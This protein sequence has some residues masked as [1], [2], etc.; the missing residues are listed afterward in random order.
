MKTSRSIEAEQDRPPSNAK[1]VYRWADLPDLRQPALYRVT[2]AGHEPREIVV[3]KNKRRVLEGLLRSP[4]F[5]ASYCRLSDQVLPLRRD[6]GINIECKMYRND[7]DTGRQKFGVY[8][9]VSSVERIE[10]EGEQ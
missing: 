1:R 6:E 4:I 9:L 3:S 2:D 7:A 10:T 5:A 8:S